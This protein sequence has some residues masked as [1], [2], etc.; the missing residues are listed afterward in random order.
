MLAGL[1]AAC[2][3]TSA[4][5][6]ELAATGAATT[7]F[8]RCALALPL[9]GGLAVAEQ[10]RHGRRSWA[11]RRAAWAA[12]LFF[13]VDLVLWNHAI[14]LVGA[15]VATVLG[16]LQVLFVALAAWLVF[17]ER[18]TARFGVALPVVIGGV[19]LVSGLVG[20]PG[21][22]NQPLAGVL[23]GAST[24]L[25][26]AAFLLILR[27][28]RGTAHVAGPLADATLGG[29]TGALVLG[30]VF[31]SLDLAPG[32]R[33]IGWLALLAFTSQSVG[34]WLITSSLP[35]LPSA[36]SSLLLL[37]QPVIALGLA[38]LV[39]GERPTWVQLVGALLI[40]AGVL[41]V[42]RRSAAAVAVAVAAPG[43][44]DGDVSGPASL[45]RA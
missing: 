39:L 25:A 11:A 29:A 23:F 20:G 34:W 42:A 27:H 3:A 43:L 19:V 35:R 9:L 2:I 41:V 8:Y 4:I 1:G 40:L 13:A 10:R 7:A 12:G 15:G 18:P 28:A 30:G 26:Y 31:G 37:L 17:K 6:V 21:V 16:N 14:N 45:R 38:A 32:W 33:A 22:G 24:S 5:L 44:E 36:V